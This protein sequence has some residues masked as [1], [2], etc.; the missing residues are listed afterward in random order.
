MCKG[1]P[2]HV[3]L[4][5]VLIKSCHTSLSQ[6][7]EE[8]PLKT[9]PEQFKECCWKPIILL[10]SGSVDVLVGMDFVHSAISV[11]YPGMSQVGSRFYQTILVSYYEI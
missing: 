3:P 11:A 7:P 8:V 10:L 2:S 4:S 5:Q 6:L 9:S 1:H